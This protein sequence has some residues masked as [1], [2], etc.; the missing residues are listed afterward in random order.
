MNDAKE[1]FDKVNK[2]VLDALKRQEEY[3]R[4]PLRFFDK[5]YEIRGAAP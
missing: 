1:L 5:Q 4:S 2:A 3:E